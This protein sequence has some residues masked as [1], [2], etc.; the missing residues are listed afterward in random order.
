MI[1]QIEPL[2]AKLTTYCQ[3]K[4]GFEN[5]PE[6]FLKQDDKNSQDPFGKTAH[7]DPGGKSVTV[8]ITVRHIKDILRSLAHE[9]VHHQQNLRGD[10]APEKCGEMSATY[11]QDNRHLRNMEKEAYLVGN[12]LFRD[13]EDSCKFSMTE[14][15]ILKENKKMS[16]PKTVKVNKNLIKNLIKKVLIEKLKKESSNAAGSVQGG[17]RKKRRKSLIREDGDPGC[18]IHD[19]LGMSHEDYCEYGPGGGGQETSGGFETRDWEL[20]CGKEERSPAL[21]PDI[22]P[23]D[24][25]ESLD[26]VYEN[27][28]NCGCTDT[29]ETPEKEKLL[30]KLRFERRE[31]KIFDKLTKLWTK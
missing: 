25:D 30:H 1:N 13:W 2:A 12:I 21:N 7:Y 9:L 23:D 15:K 16:K 10:F 20:H 18:D 14:S 4:L 29:I 19:D 31:T 8:L 24:L 27:N 11:A 6:L 22:S 28:S 26:D 3:E 5:P 17:G